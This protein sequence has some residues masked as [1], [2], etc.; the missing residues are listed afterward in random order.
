MFQIEYV[1]D[2]PD[3]MNMTDIMVCQDTLEGS[4]RSAYTVLVMCAQYGIPLLV[5]IVIYLSIFSRIKNRPQVRKK[6][7]KIKLVQRF[8]FVALAKE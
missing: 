5:V 6:Q 2:F 3:A 7:R 1:I 8:V 4:W